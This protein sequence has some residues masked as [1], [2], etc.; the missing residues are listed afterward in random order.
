MTFID[1][2]SEL[3]RRIIYILIVFVILLM[4]CFGFVSHIFDYLVSPLHEAG[5]QL[6]VISPG[7]VVTVYFSVGGIVA[8]GLTLPFALYQIWLFVRPGLT[9]L[10]RRYTVRLL[11]VTLAL[12]VAGVCFAWFIVFPRVLHFLLYLSAKQFTVN[13]RAENYFSFLSTIC[14]PFGF[15]FELPVVVVFLTRIGLVTPRFLSRIR[16]YA[17]LVIVVIGVLIS[18]PE[19][20]SHLSVTLPMVLLY[21]ISIGLSKLVERRKARQSVQQEFAK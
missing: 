4:A 6:M 3:R 5:Y 18:P 13:L 11:P 12:F 14:L 1:H 7:E 19:L 8:T 9:P 21:E 2:L 17:Y 20:I 15:I 16:R 10:E